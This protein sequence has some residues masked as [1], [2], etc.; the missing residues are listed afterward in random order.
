MLLVTT[1][2]SSGLGAQVAFISGLK[3][4]LSVPELEPLGSGSPCPGATKHRGVAMN[5][6]CASQR[7]GRF[8]TSR[9]DSSSCRKTRSHDLYE[10]SLQE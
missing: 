7:Q 3:P 8:W 5:Y 6:G 9:L 1:G 10:V 2:E 4:F